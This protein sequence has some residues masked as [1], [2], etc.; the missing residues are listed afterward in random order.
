[1]NLTTASHQWATR[2][3]DERFWTVEELAAATKKLRESAIETSVDISDL[4][5]EPH[6]ESDMA[7]MGKKNIPAAMTHYA[8]GQL[9]QTARAPARYLRTLP[10]K[11]AAENVNCGLKKA[12]EEGRSP[13][14]LLLRKDSDGDTLE[15]RA[16]LSEEYGRI[17][18]T[19]IADRLVDLTNRGWKV[20]PGRPHS[21]KDK[22]WR[23]ATTFDVLTIEGMGSG[24][25][26]EVGDKISPSGVYA[27][28][29]DMFVFMINEQEIS[30]AGKPPLYRGFFVSNSEVGDRAFRST[31]FLFQNVCGNHIVWDVENATETRIIHRG[32][33]KEITQRALG[34]MYSQLRTYTDQSTEDEVAF[35][36]DI[37]GRRIGIDQQDTVGRVHA[38]MKTILSVHQ[39][40]AA[41]ALAD[42]HPEDGHDGPDTIYGIV[43]GLT[44]LSQDTSHANERE[45]IDRAAGKVARMEF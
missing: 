3:A 33:E 12:A 29:R 16:I 11:L 44:R 13:R 23:Y 18:N 32:G 22:R 37:M 19:D 27:S 25:S 7:L 20:P 4:R 14:S 5:V 38:K 30:I 31:L 1:M 40:N 36:T 24:L 8:F 21:S 28:D 15:A 34:E 42:D 45:T 35:I 41:W 26:I 2:P 10:T 39:L 43:S 9:C 6:G 17:W